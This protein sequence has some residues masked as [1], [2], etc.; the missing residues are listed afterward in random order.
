MKVAAGS[1][2]TEYSVVGV[3]L[4]VVIPRIERT[5][6]YIITE[7]DEMEREEFYRYVWGLCVCRRVYL[8]LPCVASQ[9]S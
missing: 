4:L 8:T 7:L 1:A 9:E 5:I 6:D 2:A 3:S